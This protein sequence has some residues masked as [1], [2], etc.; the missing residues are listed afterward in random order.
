MVVATVIIFVVLVWLIATYIPWD[1][2]GLQGPKTSPNV[3]VVTNCTL[4]IAYWKAHPELYPSQMVIGG[5]VYKERELEALL[6][7]DSQDPAQQ[8]K[9][10]LVVAFLNSQAGA[11]QDSIETTLFDA[12]GWLV[13]HPPGSQVTEGELEAGRQLYDLLD[14]YNLGL[15]GVVPCEAA[16]SVTHTSTASGTELLAVSLT[17]TQTGTPTPS[18]TPTPTG[19]WTATISPTRTPVPTT[20]RPGNASPTATRYSPPQAT[21]TPTSRPPT[22]TQTSAPATSTFTPPPPP[23]PTYTLPPLPSP[24]HTIVPP[25]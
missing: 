22:A 18:E 20:Q 7:D 23:T 16:L 2:L 24:T 15:A 21:N 25:D 12:Y 19:Q 1:I 9:A 14:A 6:S 8:I 11:D 10:Q 17:P 5:I 13:Q 4:P 3:P